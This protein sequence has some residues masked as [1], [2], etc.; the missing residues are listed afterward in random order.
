[1]RG[2]CDSRSTG[3][4]EHPNFK[5]LKKH[6]KLAKAFIKLLLLMII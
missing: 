2:H 1:M 5:N 3:L 4:V 6:C